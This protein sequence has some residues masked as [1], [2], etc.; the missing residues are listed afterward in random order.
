MH[1]FLKNAAIRE[2]QLKPKNIAFFYIK[3]VHVYLI[4]FNVE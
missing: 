2:K 4:N 1:N 3:S